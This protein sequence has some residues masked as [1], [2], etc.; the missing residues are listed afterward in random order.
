MSTGNR[1]DAYHQWLGIKAADQPPHH[2]RL[3]GIELF[4]EDPEVIEN[5]ADRQMM[6]L[7]TYQ[8]G[9]HSQQSQR[10]LNEIA[11]ARICLLN[12]EKKLEYDA[13]LR[14]KLGPQ[15]ASRVRV[16]QSISP[17]PAPQP[18]AAP[19]AVM[20]VG[21]SSAQ[22]QF[23]FASSGNAARAR[24]SRRQSP[25]LAIAI[26]VGLISV[27]AI[28]VAMSSPD[29]STAA[30]PTRDDTSPASAPA[31]KTTTPRSK[32]GASKAVQQQESEPSKVT[33]TEPAPRPAEPSKTE[34]TSPGETDSPATSPVADI[35]NA[36]EPATGESAPLTEPSTG[37]VEP[38]LGEGTTPDPGETEPAVNPPAEPGEQDPRI[39]V[40]DRASREKT[41][42]LVHELYREDYAKAGTSEGREA[43]ASQ[44]FTQANATEGDPAARF[45]LLFEAAVASLATPNR[46]I[47]ADA[48]AAIGDGFRVEQGVVELQVVRSAAE[49]RDNPGRIEVAVAAMELAAAAVDRNEFDQAQ[50]MLEA[51]EP[52]V[53]KTRDRDA[54]KQVRASLQATALLAAQWRD[55]Q[56]LLDKLKMTP[57]DAD[58]HGRVG[59]FFIVVR[60]DWVA[61]L[62][63]LAQANRDTTSELA[64]KDLA[65]SDTALDQASLGHAWWDAAVAAKGPQRDRFLER[66]G[67]WYDKSVEALVGLEKAKVEK[68]LIE[69][70][71]ASGE[72]IELPGLVAHWPMDE[73]KG[74]VVGEKVANIQS[75]PSGNL[76][77]VK[78]GKKQVLGFPGAEDYLDMPDRDFGQQFTIAM[79]VKPLG[80]TTMNTLVAN[81]GMTGGGRFG[82]FGGRGFGGGGGGDFRRESGFA[83]YFDG[84]TATAGALTFSVSDGDDRETA[85]TPAG[86]LGAGRWSHVAVAVNREAAKAIIYVNGRNATSDD[87]IADDFDTSDNW[88]V[89]A[90]TSD[91]ASR[92]SYKGL[93]ADLRIYSRLL[94]A[95]EIVQVAKAQ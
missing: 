67:Y 52:P 53:L 2:Y 41:V 75:K 24:R 74:V 29:Q 81:R 84:S 37:P 21:D 17:A 42:A 20:P 30:K 34:T 63:H 62:P 48:I 13:E 72:K 80:K 51:V 50:A 59:D 35:P 82:R 91:D 40:P 3:L 11:A 33:E 38:K 26:A 22:S 18:V 27:V 46:Q 88:R 43:L 39:A 36:G 15:S 47:A 54:I 4:E 64:A 16:A 89:G 92:N 71:Q 10:I 55:I 78:D 9:Q 95:E 14:V 28:V 19:A 66:A 25:V 94:S 68:R 45:V 57:D 31:D 44:L 70:G 58:T 5:A 7:R 73:G 83:L 65:G 90:F 79:W 93:M 60:G 8:S 12:V 87:T 6:A 23:S 76:T 85:S 86:V 61:G 77:W 49:A 32:A 1:F 69:I 56:E